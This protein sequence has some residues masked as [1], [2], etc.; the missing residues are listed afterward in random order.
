MEE[1]IKEKIKELIN[2]LRERDHMLYI[3]NFPEDDTEDR[4][5][6]EDLREDYGELYETLIKIENLVK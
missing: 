4:Y 3:E 6:Y 5:D 1:K 2:N